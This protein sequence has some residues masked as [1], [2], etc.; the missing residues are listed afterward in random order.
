MKVRETEARLNA[1]FENLPPAFR[2]VPMG[3]TAITPPGIHPYHVVFLHY[4]YHGGLIAIHSSFTYPWGPTR[5]LG[6]AERLAFQ[7]QIMV[8]TNKVIE[9]SRQIILATRWFDPQGSYPTWSVDFHFLLISP[10]LDLRR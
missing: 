6:S 1:W 2:H 7:K 5:Q 4:S 8:S 3:M 9:S 10:E